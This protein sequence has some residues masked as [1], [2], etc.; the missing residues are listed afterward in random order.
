MN[1]FFRGALLLLACWSGLA[2]AELSSPLGKPATSTGSSASPAAKGQGPGV[3]SP[4]SPFAQLKPREDLVP[5]SLLTDVKTEV[6]N[7]RILPVYTPA[8]TALNQKT[9]RLQGF[10]LPLGPG[11]Q[12]THFILASVPPTCSF[13]SP[14]GPES[15]VEVLTRSPVK[16]SLNAVVVEGKFHVLQNDPYGQYYRITEAVSVK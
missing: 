5:W 7:R 14:G 8:V 2:G 3:H 9:L 10:M 15:M 13:C 16:Y 6:K 11:E 1:H 4:Q 12:Q